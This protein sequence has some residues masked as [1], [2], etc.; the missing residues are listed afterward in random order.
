M[1]QSPDL[2]NFEDLKSKIGAIKLVA[3]IFIGT[4]VVR[5]CML[6]MVGYTVF[7]RIF[8]GFTVWEG[9]LVFSTVS[10]F[11]NMFA[12]YYLHYKYLIA[13]KDV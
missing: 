11:P 7:S 9:Y 5:G 10:E 6:I 8:D 12:I 4:F 1:I 3:Y 2:Q 13:K